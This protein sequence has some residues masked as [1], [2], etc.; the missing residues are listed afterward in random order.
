MA[1]CFRVAIVSEANEHVVNGDDATKDPSKKMFQ[2]S[3]TLRRAIKCRVVPEGLQ[4][5]M[6]AFR[7]VDYVPHVFSRQKRNRKGKQVQSRLVFH[8]IALIHG[9]TIRL[10]N[11]S[12]AKWHDS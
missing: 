3:S 4:A 11:S 12:Q 5:S 1:N 9:Y 7:I 2:T 6:I 8:G 10:S